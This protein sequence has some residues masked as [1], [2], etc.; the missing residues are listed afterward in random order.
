M[1]NIS[2]LSGSYGRAVRKFLCSLCLI[3]HDLIMNEL[4]EKWM[5]DIKI[6]NQNWTKA[7]CPQVADSSLSPSPFVMVGKSRLM[8]WEMDDE[9]SLTRCACNSAMQ[10]H[11]WKIASAAA[12]LVSTCPWHSPPQDF[13]PLSLYLHW[14]SSSLSL[15]HLKA[16]LS[17]SWFMNHHLTV[18]TKTN[19][20]HP[21]KRRRCRH[22]QFGTSIRRG[23]RIQRSRQS[24]FFTHLYGAG[25]VANWRPSMYSSWCVKVSWFKG[26]SSFAG[27][28]EVKHS[29][30]VTDS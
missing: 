18:H 2:I 16:Y 12:L 19:T 13:H 30:G 27:K 25:Q 24:R 21:C 23:Q 3:T 10:T 17:R 8:R 20:R 7:L 14:I 22:W 29:G 28:I 15:I 5:L 4:S 9:V 26:N 6:I 11:N 1:C